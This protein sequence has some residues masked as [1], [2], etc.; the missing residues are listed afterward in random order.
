MR[1][2]TLAMLAAALVLPGVHQP[3]VLAVETENSRPASSTVRSWLVG[4]EQRNDAAEE[5]GERTCTGALIG[6]RHVL[7]AAH[8]VDTDHIGHLVVVTGN[9]M[10]HGVTGVE[11]HPGYL[12]GDLSDGNGLNDIAVLEIESAVKVP[13][14]RLAGGGTSR[15]GSGPGTIHGYASSGPVSAI[16]KPADTTARRIYPIFDGRAQIAFSSNKTTTCFGDSGAPLTRKTWNGNATVLAGVLS[17]GPS[18]CQKGIP[19]VFTRVE[20]NRSFIANAR[21]LLETRETTVSWSTQFGDGTL[22][23]LALETGPDGT[24]LTVSSTE[25]PSQVLL[26]VQDGDG[27]LKDGSVCVNGETATSTQLQLL[28]DRDCLRPGSAPVSI[29]VQLRGNDGRPA[30]MGLLHDVRP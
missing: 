28:L 27:E 12:G 26:F 22:L 10:V 16:M 25:Q 19:T 30:G 2:T 15:P 18:A 6:E 11:K 17:Y 23:S 21:R 8:C 9:G 5:T 4:I 20:K 3:L 7:T 1:K 13:T 24:V 29:H 14:P